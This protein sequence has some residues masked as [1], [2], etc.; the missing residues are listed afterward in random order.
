MASASATQATEYSA[1]MELTL[2]LPERAALHELAHEMYNDDR[3]DMSERG[4][5]Q[6]LATRSE[7]IPP[8]IRT[9]LSILRVD[10]AA[11]C[12]LIRGLDIDEHALPPTPVN[13]EAGKTSGTRR[14]EMQLLLLAA[15]LG[16]PFGWEG[17]QAGRLVNDVVPVQDDEE[18]QINS[19]SREAITWHTE[20]AF[21]EFPTDYI[22]LLCLRNRDEVATGVSCARD[23]VPDPRLE[24]L[25]TRPVEQVPDL[26]YEGNAQARTG[27]ALFGDPDAPYV[28]LDPYFV[29]RPVPPPV[30]DALEALDS[31]VERTMLRISLRPGDL[32]LVDNMRAVHARDSF[33]A[34]YDG[35]DRWLKRVTVS[36]DLRKAWPSRAGNVTVLRSV[37]EMG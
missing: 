3:S 2:T 16:Q 34:R 13:W 12:V 29:R 19:G 7:R 18:R 37:T 14:Q 17:Q 36:R 11:D 22:G 26:A 33:V 6:G 5:L 28:R 10:G 8:R 15:C 20:D 23:W 25:F 9:A 4:L 35:M 31:A 1:V 32:L 27:L 21:Q 24:P 30:E